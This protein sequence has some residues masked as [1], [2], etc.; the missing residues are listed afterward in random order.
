MKARN[1]VSACAPHDF[2]DLHLFRLTDMHVF[3][4]STKGGAHMLALCTHYIASLESRARA[5]ADVCE[6]GRNRKKH[7]V[8]KSK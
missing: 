5:F 7:V 3:G 4:R 6:I 8:S 2:H 1:L